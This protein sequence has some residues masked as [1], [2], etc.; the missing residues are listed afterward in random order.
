MGQSGQQH[1]GAEH[2]DQEHEGQQDPH[3]GLEL[4]RREDPGGHA[5]RQG[6]TGEEHAV[7]G[8]LQRLPVG[9]LQA[10][11]FGQNARATELKM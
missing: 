4:E 11:A 10:L 9:L 1:D 3:V 7:A 8:E 2:V 6:D 5:H